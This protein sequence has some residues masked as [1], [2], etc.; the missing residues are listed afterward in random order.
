LALQKFFKSFNDNDMRTIDLGPEKISM[1]QINIMGLLSVYFWVL[2]IR[3]DSVLLSILTGLAA[4]STL[5][6]NIV[7][8]FREKPKKRR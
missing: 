1:A 3:S 7:K 6:M 5:T 8:Y 4:L 2:Q